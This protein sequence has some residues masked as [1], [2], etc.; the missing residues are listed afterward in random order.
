MVTVSVIMITYNHENYIK[1]AIDGVLN[2][3]CSFDVELILANDNSPDSTH[4]IIQ[5]YL[6]R[7]N[8]PE[9]FEVKYV[10]HDQN[11]GMMPNFIWAMEQVSGKYIALCEGDDYW[12]DP[13]K[14]QKQVDFLEANPDYVIHSG[15]AQM[16]VNNELKEIIGNPQMKTVFAI[17]DFYTKNNLISCTAMFRKFQ[18]PREYFENILFGDWMLYVILLSQKLEFLAYVSDEVF[19]VYR[20]H[21]GGVMQTINTK[22]LSDEAHLKQILAIQ[23]VAKVEYSLNDIKN[24]NNYSLSIFD[25]YIKKRNYKKCLDIFKNNYILTKNKIYLR[26]YLGYIRYHI[27]K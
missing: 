10:K 7:T 6:S 21:E 19:A 22:H 3:L 25:H 24:I 17:T 9:N 2:Q 15:K 26:K 4:E 16:L 23:K 1:Q 8:I 5:T 11:K 14:L 12:T 20:I 27:F 13:F 18:L